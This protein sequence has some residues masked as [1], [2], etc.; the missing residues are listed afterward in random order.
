LYETDPEME[1]VLANYD[2]SIIKII[3]ISLLDIVDASFGSV[4]TAA[5]L[6]VVRVTA[7]MANYKIKEQ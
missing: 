4:Y 3:L 1:A 2:T 6:A 5:K 7:T